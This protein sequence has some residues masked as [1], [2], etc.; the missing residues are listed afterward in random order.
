MTSRTCTPNSLLKSAARIVKRQ[1]PLETD[2]QWILMEELP[3]CKSTSSAVSLLSMVSVRVAYSAA[4]KIMAG[5][6]EGW[7]EL[8]TAMQYYAWQ[9]WVATKRFDN[10]GKRQVNG[11]SGWAGAGAGNAA[12][13]LTYAMAIGWRAAECFVGDR[14]LQCVQTR[15]GLISDDQWACND[16]FV[17]FA[18]YVYCQHRGIAFDFGDHPA[19]NLG[20]YPAILGSWQDDQ[21]YAAN[22]E[23]LGD[24]HCK[25]ATADLGVFEVPPLSFIPAEMVAIE[26]LR[27]G[28]GWAPQSHQHPLLNGPLADLPTSPPSVQ[29]ILL[30]RVIERSLELDPRLDVPDW[31]QR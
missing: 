17:P 3:T 11:F 26:R 20:S 28:A 13:L 24:L 2:L 7:R 19:M 29:D 14:M 16:R 15:D 10:S 18:F 23:R 30:D 22:M 6:P 21:A 31:L 9:C 4:T 25:Q 1:R 5:S 8:H 12:Y 27:Q